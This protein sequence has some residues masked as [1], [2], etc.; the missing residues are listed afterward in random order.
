MSVNDDLAEIRICREE[1]LPYPKQITFLLARQLDVGF[2]PGM[3]KEEVAARE[4][5]LQISK[6]SKMGLRQRA[7]KGGLQLD[8]WLAVCQGFSRHAIRQQ[9]FQP[10]QTQPSVEQ[11]A[12]AEALD[13][14]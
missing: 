5:T 11:T 10:T 3:S 12:I 1:F 8:D 14:D 6:K 2:H 7:V 13:R 9:G 4:R